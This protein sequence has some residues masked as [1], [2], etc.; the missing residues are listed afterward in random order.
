MYGDN[1][2]SWLTIACLTS[3]TQG[4]R[5]ATVIA[6]LG[7]HG[8]LMFRLV[9]SLAV[10]LSLLFVCVEASGQAGRD[11]FNTAGSNLSQNPTYRTKGSVLLLKVM[12]GNKTR[13]DRQALIKLYNKNTKD[14]LWQTTNDVAEASFGDLTV[15]QYDIEVSAVGYLTAHK[16][17]N[18]TSAIVTYN[19]EIA[20]ERDPAAVELNAP[21]ASMPSKA[22]K[23]TQRAVTALKSGNHKDAQKHL[24]A[25]YKV[26][27][28]SADVN[29]LLGYLAV[30]N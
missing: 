30:Q 11:V 29:F 18:V 13:L 2:L 9:S 8:N 21:S 20:L 17:F 22:R 23:E 16:D 5:L 25:A 19:Q 12:T 1:L 26:V 28:T 24:D 10:C 3:R 7:Y 4:E 14:S 6:M 15:A 27:P